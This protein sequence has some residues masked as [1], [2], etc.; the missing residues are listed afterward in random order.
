MPSAPPAPSGPATNAP[1]NPRASRV[2]ANAS[3]TGSAPNL[4]GPALTQARA[5]RREI[6]DLVV[7]DRLHQRFERLE[8]LIRGVPAAGLE[9]EHLEP[10]KAGGMPEQVGATL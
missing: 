4:V 8:S 1:T 3:V 2:R 7:R 10:E 9:Q 6:P 5:V